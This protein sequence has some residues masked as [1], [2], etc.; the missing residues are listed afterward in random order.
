MILDPA[1]LRLAIKEQMR[2]LQSPPYLLGKFEFEMVDPMDLAE[3][4]PDA[5]VYSAYKC[6]ELNIIL[7]Y[8][9]KTRTHHYLGHPPSDDVQ[10]LLK[11]SIP[12]MPKDDD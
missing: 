7:Y 9:A 5:P 11:L 10:A 8:D 3:W 1:N 4:F 6:E 2:R 12:A